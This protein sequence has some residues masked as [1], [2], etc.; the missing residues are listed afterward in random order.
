MQE[1]RELSPA[2]QRK[3]EELWSAFENK[4]KAT[5]LSSVQ[6]TAGSSLRSPNLEDI[7]RLSELSEERR[8]A[9]RDGEKKGEIVP[10]FFG[11]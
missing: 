11:F 2:H 9:E 3:I 6:A 10:V 8:S 7:D 4:A 5:H 1:E